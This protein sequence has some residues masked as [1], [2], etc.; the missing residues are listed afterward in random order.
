[1]WFPGVRFQNRV[2]RD[3][4]FRVIAMTFKERRHF[5]AM[6]QYAA[7][8]VSPSDKGYGQPYGFLTEEQESAFNRGF[9]ATKTY[10]RN[11]YATAGVLW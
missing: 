9:C 1:M 6:G 8:A 3:S 5:F 11:V 10:R 4:C 7:Y 2:L